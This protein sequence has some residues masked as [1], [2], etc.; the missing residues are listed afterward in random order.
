MANN[1]EISVTESEIMGESIHS[2]PA[3][4]K[5]VEENDVIKMMKLLFD[6]QNTRLDNFSDKFNQFDE[7]F[8]DI[9]KEIKK[10]NCN[11]DERINEIEIHCD[12]IQKQT[13][14]SNEQFQ[15]KWL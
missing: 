11:F 1:S 9:K 12:S 8:N 6:E 15:S 5:R 3:P 14:T 2:T 7:Q 10:Q 4:T 13:E